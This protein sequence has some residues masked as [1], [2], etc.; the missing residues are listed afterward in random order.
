MDWNHQSCSRIPCDFKPSRWLQFTEKYL[1]AHISDIHPHSS[2]SLQTHPH[3]GTQHTL[4]LTRGGMA[5]LT[6]PSSSLLP[7]LQL[8]HQEVVWCLQQLYQRR[9]SVFIDAEMMVFFPFPNNYS[10]SDVGLH[11]TTLRWDVE[12]LGERF[13]DQIKI[14]ASLDGASYRNKTVDI[15]LVR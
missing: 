8:W 15:H 13:A 12:T 10:R 14:T 11:E 6:A 7:L 3:D 1:R 5:K 2:L 4:T 9:R